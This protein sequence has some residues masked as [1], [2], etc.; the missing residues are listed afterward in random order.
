MSPRNKSPFTLSAGPA[1]QA[2]PPTPRGQG[3]RYARD[4]TG[5]GGPPLSAV[6]GRGDLGTSLLFVFPLFL[7]YGVGVLFAPNM[8]GV[9]FVSKNLYALVGYDRTNY[10][11][12]YGVLLVGFVALLLWERRRHGFIPHRFLP[13]II[14]STIYALTLG[15]LIL[16]VMRNV[17]GFTPLADGGLPA[18]IGGFIL[19]VGAGVYEELVFRLGLLSGSAALLRL[20]GAPH[21]LAVGVAFLL[22]SA[23]FSAAHHIGANGDAWAWSVFTYRMLAGL[24]F[25]AIYYWRSLA[26]AAYTHA[27]YDVYVVLVGH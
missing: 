18:G 17:L 23:L 27:L 1:N 16:F 14:E 5:H 3:P 2:G 8:N 15:T 24:L 9:D 10:L 22:S 6:F 26:H 20:I 21:G 25:A 13:M 12:V 19:S 11:L 7:I 4:R